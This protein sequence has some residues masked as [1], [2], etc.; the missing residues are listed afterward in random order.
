M[1]DCNKCGRPLLSHTSPCTSGSVEI[2]NWKEDRERLLHSLRHIVSME[3]NEDHDESDTPCP[4]RT[5]K[6]A[7]D[8]RPCSICMENK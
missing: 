7:I 2:D 8:N 4:R 5:A 3:C 1:S 6:E